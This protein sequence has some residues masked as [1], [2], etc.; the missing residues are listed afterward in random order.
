M[1]LFG[2]LLIFAIVTINRVK[3]LSLQAFFV[4]F[5]KV[6]ILVQLM[7]IH[8][9]SFST[10]LSNQQWELVSISNAIPAALFTIV[11]FAFNE[12]HAK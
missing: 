5:L 9:N 1:P 3:I 8:G 7:L 10:E 6:L 4:S 2:L 11:A 12:A